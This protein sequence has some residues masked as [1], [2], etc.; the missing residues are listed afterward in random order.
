MTGDDM[1]N[2]RRD[3]VCQSDTFARLMVV[4]LDLTQRVSDN[5]K[6]NTVLLPQ[7]FASHQSLPLQDHQ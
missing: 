1:E 7:P 2:F 4:A 6:P 3:K 5:A